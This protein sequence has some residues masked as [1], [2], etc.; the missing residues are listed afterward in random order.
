MTVDFELELDNSSVSQKI[1]VSGHAR[2]FF[3]V[4]ENDFPHPWT[5]ASAVNPDS[6]FRPSRSIA[7]DGCTRFAFMEDAYVCMRSRLY[8]KGT[9]E[10]HN[11][12]RKAGGRLP[13]R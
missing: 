5:Q 6:L 10:R 1:Q 2:V 12:R 13:R 4:Q 9:P 7:K 11:R 3:R 8:D